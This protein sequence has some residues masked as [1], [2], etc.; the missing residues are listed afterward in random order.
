[1]KN[2]L[3]LFVLTLT[4]PLLQAQD[5][6][7]DEVFAE[8]SVSK[9]NL[10]GANISI[11]TGQPGLDSLYY[12]VYAP[13]GDT[14]AERPVVLVLPTGTFLP[15][16]VFAPTGAKDDYANV[17]IATR[18]AQRGYVAI[19]MDYRLGWN[20]VADDDVTRRATILQAAYR[21]IQDVYSMIRF[22]NMTVDDLANPLGIDTDKLTI[23][24]VGTGGFVG[25][26]MAVLDEPETEI[27]IPKFVDP[28]Y[29]VPF[30][31]TNA[32]G[33]LKNTKPGFLEIQGQMIPFNIP[34]HVGYKEDFHFVFGL[35]GAVGDSSWMDTG[36]VTVPMVCAGTVTH[37]TTPFGIDP[38]TDEINCDLPVFTGV[39]TGVFVVN[40]GGSACMTKKA[41]ELGYNAPLERFV[42]DDDIS[43]ALIDQQYAQEHLWA[44]NRPGPEAGPWEFWDSTFWK[45]VPAAS[46]DFDNIHEAGIATNPDMSQMKADAYIDTALWFFSP[47]ACA[48]LELGDCGGLT[49]GLE[50]LSETEY[51][52]TVAPNPARSEVNLWIDGNDQ[53]SRVLIVDMF[54][55]VV[56]NY[57][58][59]ESQNFSFDVSNL[60]PGMYAIQVELGDKGFL[61]SKLMVQK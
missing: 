32:L 14:M 23:F 10:Y 33:D 9:D 35:D 1:M 57:T 6:Y 47:R 2:R 11:I 15:R 43:D 22:L 38:I 4:F 24:G 41:N 17:Q 40:I 30:I 12:D 31:D 49:S 45:Q 55:K 7:I 25:F 56:A 46:P 18:L 5:R 53:M 50:D 26:N 20:P 3:L 13:V 58:G 39:G 21:S 29:G 36:E 59:M 37:P 54:G 8:V 19:S 27:Y 16:G 42:W 28:I 60:A 52:F 51:N 48:T 44:I 34:L 61:S